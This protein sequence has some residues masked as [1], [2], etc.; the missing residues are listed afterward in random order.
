MGEQKQNATAPAVV[1]RFAEARGAL[2]HVPST[3]RTRPNY[4]LPASLSS[5]S[6]RPGGHGH[7][8]SEFEGIPVQ[9]PASGT[10]SNAP[11]FTA[12]QAIGASGRNFRF[13]DLRWAHILKELHR[14]Y[15]SPV[16]A[17]S[18][19]LLDRLNDLDYQHVAQN[20]WAL[21]LLHQVQSAALTLKWLLDW[22]APEVS[23]L[24]FDD[25]LGDVHLYGDYLRTRGRAV[26]HFHAV[27]DEIHLRDY[28]DWC[29]LTDAPGAY[30]PPA[31]TVIAHS[32]GSVMSFD[33]LTYA[34]ARPGVRRDDDRPRHASGSVPFPDYTTPA[35]GEVET[36]Q[37]LMDGLR[38]LPHQVAARF[39][40]RF[41]RGAI[42][43]PDVP[44]VLWRHDVA[45]FVTLGS[46]GDKFHVLWPRNYEHMRHPDGPADPHG[47]WLDAD[48][49]VDGP[50][51]VH[52][53]FCDE[54]DPVGHHLDVAHACAA[55]PRLFDVR[56]PVAFRDVVFRRY[57][58]PG[59]AHTRYWDDHA[60]FARILDVVVDGR[61]DDAHQEEQLL[62]PAF[63]ASRAVYTEAL[64]WAYFRVPFAAALV[65]GLL[66][67]YG[68]L[69][70]WHDGLSAPRMYRPGRSRRALAGAHARTIGRRPGGNGRFGEGCWRASWPAPSNGGAS[71]SWSAAMPSR[72]RNRPARPVPAWALV[73]T[74]SS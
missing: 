46:P 59:L 68:G 3:G 13:V 7:G 62:D 45:N 19:R 31:Y 73:T 36:W 71:S 53:N 12:H 37:H 34:F 70:L 44:H 18:K 40:D 35:A 66:V 64:R 54:Q 9:P 67:S 30:E 14:E 52:Y 72:I 21:P 50:T 39:T 43:P 38:T 33:A 56:S 63:R 58:V 6:I 51:I 47:D 29:R 27:L 26:R 60:L 11:R 15:A 69:G 1:Q 42:G 61:R 17:W 55:Y 20:T 22:R 8:W 24:I 5:Q 57:G 28:I 49:L 10:P 2:D 16:E 65:T 4:L 25:I 48:A 74:C 32:L 23:R 41:G